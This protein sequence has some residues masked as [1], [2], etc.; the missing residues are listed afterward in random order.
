MDVRALSS[1]HPHQWPESPETSGNA[2]A[3]GASSSGLQES[4]ASEGARGASGA[5]SGAHGATT[6]RCTIEIAVATAAC[7]EAIETRRIPKGIMCAVETAVAV[8]CLIEEHG[9][10]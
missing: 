9:R 8:Q 1:Q 6:Q 4:R 10:K 7:A 5:S 3:G 2:G